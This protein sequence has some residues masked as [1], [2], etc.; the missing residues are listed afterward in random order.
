MTLLDAVSQVKCAAVT[1]IQMPACQNASATKCCCQP[2]G[3]IS[4]ASV[5]LIITGYYQL[6]L[7]LLT[8]LSVAGRPCIRVRMGVSDS[9]VLS[10]YFGKHKT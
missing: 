3:I 4:L 8:H 2:R 9:S 5:P 7:H 6:W 1:I 10:V